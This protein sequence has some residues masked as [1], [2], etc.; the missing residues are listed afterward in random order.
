MTT[1]KREQELLRELDEH[2]SHADERA[3]PLSSELDP[4]QRLKGSV[5]HYERPFEPLEDWDYGAGE[6]E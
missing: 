3:E 4:L 5:V 1:S 6:D 2:T